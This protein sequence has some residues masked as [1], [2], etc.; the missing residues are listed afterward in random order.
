MPKITVWLSYLNGE[1]IKMQVGYEKNRD[2]RLI[3][4]SKTIQDR[5]MVI[6]ERDYK[7]V[8]IYRMVPSSM[9][10]NEPRF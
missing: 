6:M 8:H 3:A 5:V 4:T 2:F 1:V 9:T 10:L 7:F